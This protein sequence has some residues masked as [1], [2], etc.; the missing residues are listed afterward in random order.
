M[1]HGA[2]GMT[3][4]VRDFMTTLV[5]T[6]R[7][8]TPFRVIVTRMHAARAGAVP[9]ID[10]CGPVWGLVSAHD[11]LAR[12]GHPDPRGPGAAGGLTVSP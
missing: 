4:A 6:V 10:D 3:R 12:E 9:V 8:D 7:Q 1:V 2:T 11:L 5:M